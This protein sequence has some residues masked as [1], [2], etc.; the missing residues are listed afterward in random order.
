[1]TLSV[2][3][4]ILLKVEKLSWE[5]TVSL[6]EGLTKQL[7]GSGP[8]IL[9]NFVHQHRITNKHGLGKHEL[10]LHSQS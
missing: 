3:G 6:E 4:P 7:S 10:G 2:G 9:T 8:L 1:M 5:P